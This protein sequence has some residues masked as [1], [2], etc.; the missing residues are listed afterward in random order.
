LTEEGACKCD[1]V[2]PIMLER[3]QQLSQGLTSD[4][5]RE[6]KRLINKV[7]NCAAQ[8]EKSL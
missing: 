3:D 6:F 4:E 1:E 5:R 8:I 7:K 2:L